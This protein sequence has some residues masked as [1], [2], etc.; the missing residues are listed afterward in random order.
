MPVCCLQAA[1]N[2]ELRQHVLRGDIAPEAFVRMTAD[3]LASKVRPTLSA[4]H[5]LLVCACTVLLMLL[6]CLTACRAA[7]TATLLCDPPVVPC[8]LGWLLQDLQQYR[9][10]RHLESLRQ[11]ELPPELAAAV[12]LA[13]AVE[14]KQAGR[15]VCC[16]V[17]FGGR[18]GEGGVARLAWRRAGLVKVKAG[19]GGGQAR[20]G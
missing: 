13:A 19:P 20:L 3:E 18:L 4:L 1:G 2:P 7:C 14:L 11:A 12:S 5:V 17:V 6:Y 10:S 8:Y 15:W 9:R 16:A